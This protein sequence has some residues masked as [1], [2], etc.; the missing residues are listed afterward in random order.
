MKSLQLF[1]IFLLLTS[2]LIHAKKA[3][4]SLVEVTTIDQGIITP[5]QNFRGY[6]VYETKA[7]IASQTSGLILKINFKEGDNIEKNQIL[8]EVDSEIL[9]SHITAKKAYIKAHKNEYNR[10]LQEFERSK[11][12]FKRKN[13]SKNSYEVLYYKAQQL[14]SE[15]LALEA[16]LTTLQIE[17]KQKSVKAP[18]SGVVI[19][20]TIEVGEWI[21][22]AQ[23]A[24][25]LADTSTTLA[26]VHLP[27][28]SY[29][30]LKSYHDSIELTLNSKKFKATIERLIPISDTT[31]HSFLAKLKLNKINNSNY[32]EG[33]NIT[34]LLPVLS[35]TK[36]FLVPRDAVIRKFSQNVIFVVRENKAVMIPV[37]VLTYADKKAAI[38]PLNKAD[39]LS[40]SE[41][42]IIKGN[43]RIF[44]NTTVT[45]KNS[46]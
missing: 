21:T 15:T 12:L 5:T 42:V 6:L 3:R 11:E 23:E 28:K 9:Q 36:S 22:T 29:E 40:L 14:E 26:Y 17:L 13:I 43:E 16:E 24:L 1:I 34:A 27:A 7:K 4:T 18:F 30:K 46:K 25:V 45:I 10:I 2:S 32:I 33:Q 35:K 8:F 44:P 19:S 37:K 39:V 41:Q 31:T 20:K 38:E